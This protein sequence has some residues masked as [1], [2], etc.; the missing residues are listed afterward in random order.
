MELDLKALWFTTGI[1]NFGI[2]ELFMIVVGGVLLYLAIARRFEPLLLVPIGFGA[3]LSNVP[4]AAMAGPDGLLGYIYTVGIETG[5]FPM[6]IFLGLGALTDFGALIANPRTLLL[7]AAAQVGIFL[8]MMGALL[9]NYLPGFY[10]SLQ[11]AAAI[12][13]FGGA[14]VPTAI[15]VS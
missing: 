3:I 10:F 9:L 6:L 14:Y 1:A 11:D 13:F 5:V 8:T 15:F 4:V 12:G 7:G 2:G